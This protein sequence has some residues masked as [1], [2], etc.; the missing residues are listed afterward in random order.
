VTLP[1][2]I[3]AAGAGENWVHDYRIPD[4]V[5]ITADRFGIIK[6]TH[7]EGPPNVV[8][9]IHSPGDETYEKLSFYFKVGIPEVWIIHRDTRTVQI[10]VRKRSRYQNV[11]AQAKGWL[12]SP[13]T[14]I[15]LRTTSNKKLCIRVNGDDTTRAELPYE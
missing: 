8:I 2:N 10:C 4:L 13:E 12:R 6:R 9:E 5:L 14:G 1:Q 3:A 11:K 15:E 7:L